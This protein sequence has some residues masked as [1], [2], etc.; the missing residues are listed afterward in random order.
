MTTMST[1]QKFQALNA[2]DET[3]GI[4]WSDCTNKWYISANI[5]IADGAGLLSPTEHAL[6]IEDAIENYWERVT[7]L[8]PGCYLA[9]EHPRRYFRW[10]GF[11]WQQFTDPFGDSSN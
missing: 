11:M 8:E 1:T 10:N 9:R 2:L 4:F 5:Y 6:S 7:D 3:I